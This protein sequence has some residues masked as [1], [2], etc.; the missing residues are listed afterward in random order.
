MI[1]VRTEQS[2]FDDFMATRF[3]R[4]AD[5]AADIGVVP[6]SRV[7]AD[8]PSA[9]HEIDLFMREQNVEVEDVPWITSLLAVF[10]GEFLVNRFGGYWL[11]C[12]DPRS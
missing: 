8:P 3:D 10:V 4:L 6:P 5:F 11:I 9:L 7:V 12:D 2:V 1:N